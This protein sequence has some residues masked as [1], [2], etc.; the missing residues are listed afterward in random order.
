MNLSL[1]CSEEGIRRAGD[2]A[3]RSKVLEFGTEKWSLL[4]CIF[5]GRLRTFSIYLTSLYI[6]NRSLIW[7]GPTCR[8]ATK[9]VHHNYRA[10]ALEPGSSSYWSLCT[11]GA[12]LCNGRSHGNKKPRHCNSGEATLQPEALQQ[13]RKSLHSNGDPAQPKISKEMYVTHMFF[14]I[15]LCYR[16]SILFLSFTLRFS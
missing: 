1:L 5:H 9:P 16:L 3:H 14:I 15:Y 10:C 8:G 2:F 11:P 7:E 4:S 12:T 13:Q 6:F